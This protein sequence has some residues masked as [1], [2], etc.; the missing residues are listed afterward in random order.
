MRDKHDICL[1]LHNHEVILS[2]IQTSRVSL[3]SSDVIG[4][5]LADLLILLH[6]DPEKLHCY[7]CL[8]LNTGR[9]KDVS[10]GKLIFTI[11]EVLCFYPASFHQTLETIIH[12]THTYVKGFC[13]VT[14]TNIR[15]IL[16]L[17]QDLVP[18]RIINHYGNSKPIIL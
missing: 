6:P 4:E 1:L 14:L 5:F 18:K 10:I 9:C 7:P 15:V 8:L 12:L 17:L 2:G 16:K 13:K 3:N 11:L